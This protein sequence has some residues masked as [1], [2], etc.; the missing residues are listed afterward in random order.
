MKFQTMII[1][2][3]KGSLT[4]KIHLGKGVFEKSGNRG[5]TQ[6]GWDNS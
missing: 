3:C 6:G 5:I 4:K 1:R 2:L